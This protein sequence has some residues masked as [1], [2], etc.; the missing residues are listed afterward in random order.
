M[1]HI[2]KMI[3][4]GLICILLFLQ[5]SAFTSPLETTEGHHLES[6]IDDISPRDILQE[7]YNETLYFRGVPDEKS[8]NNLTAYHLDV[9]QSDN[10]SYSERLE[11]GGDYHLYGIRVWIRHE[12]HTESEL[13]DGEAVAVVNRTGQGEGMQN[14]TWNSPEHSMEPTDS[15][16]VR[17][18]KNRTNES[19]P[20]PPE[21]LVANFTTEQLGATQLD[22]STWTVNYYTT[23]DSPDENNYVIWGAPPYNT[24]I[25]NFSYSVHEFY[26][27]PQISNVSAD[28]D[29]QTAGD[30][31]NI[32]CDV[33][34][35]TGLANVRANI[36]RPDGSH[37]NV[38]MDQIDQDH[39]YFNDTYVLAGDHTYSILAE[40]VQGQWNESSGHSFQIE[41]GPT[42]YLGFDNID[43]P[44]VAGE[45]FEVNISAYDSFDNRV[46]DYNGTAAL[47]DTTGTL[48][49]QDTSQ[50]SEGN[51]KGE[52]EITEARNDIEI[53]ATDSDDGSITGSSNSFNVEPSGIDRFSITPEDHSITAGDHVIYSA[54]LLDEF[55]NEIDDVSDETHWSIEEEAG[56]GWDDSVYTSQVD[57]T[58]N[59][60]GEYNDMEETVLLDVEAGEVYEVLLSPDEPQE[61]SAGEPIDFSA[62][63]VD[64][65]GNVITSDN[66]D[67][68]WSGADEDG[69]F[70][71]TSTG[72]YS[73]TAEYEE[74]ISEPVFV[75]VTPSDPVS[76]QVSPDG[77]SV[78]AGDYRSFFAEA[79]DEYGNVF[80]VT[81]ETEF[82]IDEEAKGVWFDNVYSSE[83]AGVWN[84]TGYYEGLTNTVTVE[85][86]PPS[87]DYISISADPT[88]IS[89]G[90]VSLFTAEA[91]DEFGNYVSDVT[92]YTVWEIDEEAGGSFLDNEYTSE[93]TGTWNVTGIYGDSKDYMTI[94]VEPTEVDDIAITPQDWTVEAGASVEY[95]AV[96][97][98]QFGNPIEDV[99]DEVSWNIESE[100]EGSWDGNIYSSWSVGTWT[101]T[102]SMHPFSDTA[103]LTVEPTDLDPELFQIV[104]ISGD[105]QERTAGYTT[106]SP[107]VVEVR[108]EFGQPVGTGWRVWFNVTDTGSDAEIENGGTILTDENGRAET[109]LRLGSEA[110]SNNVSAELS[111]TDEFKRTDFSIRGTLPDIDIELSLN[112]DQATSGEIVVYRV[113]IENTGDEKASDLWVTM[114]I[115]ERLSY[116]SDTSDVGVIQ[117]GEY[118]VWHFNDVEVGTESFNIVCVVD[119]NIREKQVIKTSLEL[120]Y[121]NSQGDPMPLT[122][123][124]Q[125]SLEID[126]TILEKI[127]WPFPL[128]PFI[129]LLLGIGWHFYKKVEVQDVFLIHESG[130]LLANKSSEEGSTMDD[131]LFS[132]MLTA[133]QDFIKDSFQ[134]EENYGIKRLE[135]GNKKILVQKGK[136]SFIALVYQ[137]RVVGQVEQQMRSILKD[138][139]SEYEE[140]LNSWD[141]DMA[142]LD[143][144]E[145]YLE[146]FF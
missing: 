56:G 64:D 92:D 25:E 127:Y 37:H 68:E 129:A 15:V 116:D 42:N 107:L 89:A 40:D 132:S 123:S 143:G 90:D 135:F 13:T 20:P 94:T 71:E 44:Q 5:S 34:S 38:S 124:N 146:E 130:I 61:T 93:F 21:T 39:F 55:D 31:V 60:T 18:Y 70:L 53:T 23:R 96:S 100:A 83:I 128:I 139:E 115:H 19:P 14:N 41:P 77:S 46:T 9:N 47:Q 67:F 79:R 65:Q 35:E 99:T 125:V 91:Y 16:V 117:D 82:T 59:V 54:V 75:E 26:D 29:V 12:N 81:D 84:V 137:G 86:K 49:P 2:K 8:V 43:S 32:S 51:W 102:A 122:S 145:G 85:V 72:E 142:R 131:D 97:K 66:D 62:E 11:T 76:L 119:E 78:Q 121:T 52:V 17:L 48:E 69:Q 80:N 120:E 63:A 10:E 114:E 141:G 22:G 6:D 45:S 140:G 103:L 106:D 58:W 24:S 27:P 111:G 109:W 144:V 110:G 126:S 87:V 33:T 88:N 138:I 105:H 136:Y 108:D 104:K 57:G 7:E 134:G 101:V 50:F 36:T 95:T 73:V 98:D 4:P 112:V 30:S 3:I 133:I 113:D 28:P 118:F 74:V 1:D